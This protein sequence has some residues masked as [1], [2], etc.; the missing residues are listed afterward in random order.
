MPLG[1]VTV[2]SEALYNDTIGVQLP[3]ELLVSLRPELKEIGVKID[4]RAREMM[5]KARVLLVEA[6][7]DAEFQT[8]V[9]RCL[10]F[11]R[12]ELTVCILGCT[13]IK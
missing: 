2:A 6:S 5:V 1:C 3:L 10:K 12:T 8:Q 9:R 7:Q 4:K 13:W 11:S